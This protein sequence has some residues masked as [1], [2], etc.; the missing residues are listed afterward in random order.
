MVDGTGTRPHDLNDATDPTT[1]GVAASG[2]APGGS[3]QGGPVLSGSVVPADETTKMIPGRLRSRLTI[4]GLVVTIA[5]AGL[6]ASRLTVADPSVMGLIWAGLVAVYLIGFAYPMIVIRKLSITVTACPSDLVVGQLSSVAVDLRGRL[7]GLT[8]RCGRSPMFVVDITSPDEVE[9]P[10][11]VSHR[12]AYD[13]LP[14]EVSSDAPFSIV[15]ASTRR[16]VPLPR[17]LLVGPATIPTTAELGPIPGDR[18]DVPSGGRAVSGDT[19][20]SVRPYVVGDPAH[21][22][23]WPSSARLGS[24]VVRELEPP[25]RLGVAVVVQLVGPNGDPAVESAVSRAAGV[26]IDALERGGRVLICTATDTGPVTQEVNGELAVRRLLALATAGPLP[27]VPDGWPIQIVTETVGSDERGT[28][29]A[30]DH[31]GAQPDRDP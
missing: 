29:R 11:E 1:A 4:F 6:P 5:V 22:V 24:L 23:H 27:A 7:S 15:M 16:V 28:E 8:A 9:L 2:P 17:Q 3:T 31:V 30:D 13:H 10:L 19:V 14:V 20:R 21:M 18:S 12:G 26:A 25:R